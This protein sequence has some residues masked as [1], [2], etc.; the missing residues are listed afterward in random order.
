ML[1]SF[2]KTRTARHIRAA[3]LALAGLSAVFAVDSSALAQSAPPAFAV[4]TPASEPPAVAQLRAEWR[5]ANVMLIRLNP[6]VLTSAAVGAPVSFDL[7][8]TLRLTGVTLETQTLD[9]G[10]ILWSGKFGSPGNFMG[11]AIIVIDGDTVTALIQSPQGDMYEI[12][13]VGSGLN[14]V[15]KIDPGILPECATPIESPGFSNPIPPPQPSSSAPTVDVLVAY[16]PS[17]AAS[18]GDIDSEIDLAVSEAN[19]SFAN[20]GINANLRLAGTMA[21]NY[22]EPYTG[23]DTASAVKDWIQMLADLVNNNSVAAQRNATGAEVVVLLV[24][25]ARYCGWANGINVAATNQAYA[26]VSQSCATDDYSFG[27]EIGLLI[28]A[29]NGTGTTTTATPYPYGHGHRAH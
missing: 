8:P 9:E 10:R 3:A 16:T 13:P 18:A 17:A 4:V 20:N 12:R 21:L 22:T 29:G 7:T 24:N 28:G 11:T 23:S 6:G 27:H 15:I 5:H 1:A 19:T 26:L 14:A 2:W 25:D